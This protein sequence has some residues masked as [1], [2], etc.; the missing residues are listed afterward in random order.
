[1]LKIYDL[2]LLKYSHIIGVCHNIFGF[3]FGQVY[4]LDVV[5]IVNY[6]FFGGCATIIDEFQGGGGGNIFE[7]N[8]LDNKINPPIITEDIKIYIESL[9]IKI[10]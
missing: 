8:K 9:V 10:K 6:R 4:Y 7:K 3:Y 2:I 1:M 5:K